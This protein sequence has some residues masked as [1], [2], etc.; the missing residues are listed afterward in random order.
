MR[1]YVITERK[2]HSATA[3]HFTECLSPLKQ[4]D[5]PLFGRAV[6]IIEYE[7]SPLVRD[8]MDV[9]DEINTECLPQADSL[10]SYQLTEEEGKH[11]DKVGTHFWEP[12]SK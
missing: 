11:A 6:I 1:R 7:N 8:I 3:S 10:R 4:A 9:V 2:M 12:C 5:A